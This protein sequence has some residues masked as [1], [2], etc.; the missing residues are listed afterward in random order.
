M[1]TNQ[2]KL[3][4]IYLSLGA[5]MF[6]CQSKEAAERRKAPNILFAI[7]DDQSLVLHCKFHEDLNLAF[8]AT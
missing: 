7:A 8:L 2:F 3:I 4:I 1:A 6:G 5:T